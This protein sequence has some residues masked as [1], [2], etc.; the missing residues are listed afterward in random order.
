MYSSSH[1]KL[2]D[3]DKEYNLHHKF[4]SL[5]RFGQP[6]YWV[7]VIEEEEAIRVTGNCFYVQLFGNQ[8]K[9]LKFKLYRDNPYTYKLLDK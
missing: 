3:C 2:I 6:H 5:D 8:N 1:D 7:L 4:M 9:P